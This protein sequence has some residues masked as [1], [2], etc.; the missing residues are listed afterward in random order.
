MAWLTVIAIA[1]D[2]PCYNIQFNNF[3]LYM[4]CTILWQPGIIYSIF[5]GVKFWNYMVKNQKKLLLFA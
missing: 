2:L 5:L 1:S 3:Y 4:L